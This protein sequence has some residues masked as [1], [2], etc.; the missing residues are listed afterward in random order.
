MIFS[1][2][3]AEGTIYQHYAS[4]GAKV[5]SH[6]LW[7]VLQNFG[8]KTYIFDSR[9]DPSPLGQHTCAHTGCQQT[10]FGQKGVNILPTGPTDRI[11]RQQTFG[12]SEP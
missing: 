12:S 1:F 9:N 11:C 6:G 5:N 3:D 7:Q 2:F 10:V 8:Q 4:L